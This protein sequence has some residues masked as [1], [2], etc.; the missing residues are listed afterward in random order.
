MWGPQL[1]ALW[2]LGDWAGTGGSRMAASRETLTPWAGK[3]AGARVGSQR[4]GCRGSPPSAQDELG[5]LALG[6]GKP[7]EEGGL[8]VT[9]WWAVEGGAKSIW[10]SRARGFWNTGTA[11]QQRVGAGRNQR[12]HIG[13]PPW[14]TCRLVRAPP[15]RRAR[16]SAG[17]CL[18][19]TTILAGGSTRL[20]S[21]RKS[22]SP[23]TG[24][25]LP[26]FTQ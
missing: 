6:A 17:S 2:A 7:G 12:H 16:R 9:C 18:L 3:E 8:P 14:L 10:D 1:R 20:H 24:S 5:R 13:W 25:D 22:P 23:E 11:P 21:N 4:V 15:P 19:F 26:K